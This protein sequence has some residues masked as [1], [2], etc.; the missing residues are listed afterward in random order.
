MSEATSTGSHH[1]LGGRDRKIEANPRLLSA[2]PLSRLLRPVR[3]HLV[4]CALLSALG[5]AAGLLPYLAIAEISRAA[6]AA[7]GSLPEQLIGQWTM[8]GIAGAALRP[9][10][11]FA[12]SRL[13]HYADAEILHDLRLQIL[14]HL[15]VVP[16]GWFRAVG[17]GVVKKAM[18]NDLEIM[19]QLIAH[20]LGEIIGAWTAIILGAT[21]LALIDW[22][23]ALV[24]I[25]VLAV[26]AIFFQVAMRSMP[27]H[28]AR[29]LAAEARISAASIEY[30]DGITVVKTF[31]TGGRIL[32]R[33]N[34]AV[35][36]HGEAFKTWIDEVRYSSA[37]D[38]WLASEMTLLAAVMAAGLWFI[39]KDELPVADLLP[40]LIVGIGLPT[41]VIPAV[42]GAQGLRQGRM[43]AGHIE[44]LLSLPPLPEPRQ[45]HQPKGNQIEF[46]RVSFSYDG[47]T[48][49]LSDVSFDCAPGSMTALVGPSGAGKSTIASLLARFYEVTLGSIKIG[50]ADLRAI[51]T[52]KLLSSLALVFQDVALLRDTV[53]ENMRV[54]RPGASDEDVIRAATA[55]QIH[56]VIAA[57]PQGYDTVLEAGGS[58]SGGER[59][60]LTIARAILSNAPIVVLDEATAALDPENEAAIQQGLAALAVGKTVIVIAHRLKTITHADQIIVLDK[61]RIVELGRHEELIAKGG[62]YARLWAAQDQTAPSPAH[63]NDNGLLR[64][65]S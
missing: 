45:P 15:G 21:Y 44:S 62:L 34:K 29:L 22:R 49:A 51:S 9:V 60:R 58:L 35:R 24:A 40:F 64:S 55:A 43:A 47:V 5:S 54:G 63:G 30:A 65:H 28:M 8:I 1:V 10:L 57:L 23:M 3:Y 14:R 16:L 41:A 39:S 27:S 33:F 13:G 20:A 46:H 7:Q 31:G 48:D 4:V 52:P 36:E 37:L 6:I 18:T 53:R 19:H 12:S 2:G 38:R 42:H 56:D 59:Q 17:T 50:G 25:S 32:E 26:T 61:G 11:L